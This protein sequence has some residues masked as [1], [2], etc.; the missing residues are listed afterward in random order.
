MPDQEE[1]PAGGRVR[2]PVRVA[3]RRHT[4]VEALPANFAG[5]G[6]SAVGGYLYYLGS[7]GGGLFVVLRRGLVVDI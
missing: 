5:D 4:G 6:I 7:Y 1:A 2:S 3:V